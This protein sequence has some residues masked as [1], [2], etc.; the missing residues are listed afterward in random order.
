MKKLITSIFFILAVQLSYGYCG[1]K[2]FYG[3]YESLF[4]EDMFGDQEISEQIRQAH[5]KSQITI[6]IQKKKHNGKTQRR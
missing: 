4:L 2:I 3:Y 6:E 1:D 5:E